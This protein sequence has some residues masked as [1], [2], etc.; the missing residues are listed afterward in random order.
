MKPYFNDRQ[1]RFIYDLH[2]QGYTYKEL[3]QWLGISHGTIQ[4][5]FYRL[6]FKSFS[7]EPLSLYDEDL[8]ALGGRK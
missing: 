7:R 5:N 6:E 4:Y 1:W 2:C 8:R 3:S